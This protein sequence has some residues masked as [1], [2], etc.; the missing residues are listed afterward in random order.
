MSSPRADFLA[1]V[2]DV[3]PLLLG[4]VPFGL[5]VGVG[6]IAAGIP[7]AH[8]VGMSAFIFGGASQLAAADLIANDAPA[9]LVVLVALVVNIRFMMYSASIAPHFRR[10]ADRWK[11]VV[12]AFL[13]DMNYALSITRFVD[14][15]SVDRRWYYLGV[16]M[17]MWAVWVA[18]TAVGVVV[19]AR[20]PSGLQLEFA[21]PLVFIA[22]AVRA[23]DDRATAAAAITAGLLAVPGMVFPLESGLLIAAVGGIV[24]GMVI[25]GVTA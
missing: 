9:L 5:V 20:V 18:T 15:E 14:D 8:A 10:L 16:S 23:I 7:A 1:G 19:G 25:E 4:V 17:P 21:I 24:V 12:A 22:L 3:T 13:V 11:W 2:R 6:L